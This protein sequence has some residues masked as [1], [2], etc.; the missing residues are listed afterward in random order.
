VLKQQL[1]IIR[2][3][4]YPC[5]NLGGTVLYLP[6]TST[7]LAALME[8]VLIDAECIEPLERNQ[9]VTN[10]QQILGPAKPLPPLACDES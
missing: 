9:Q 5:E 6:H 2:C 7:L 3:F 10:R 8:I 1:D 4:S